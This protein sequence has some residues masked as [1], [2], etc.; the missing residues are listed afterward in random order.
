[1]PQRE[2]PT[3]PLVGVGAIIV[4]EQARVLLIQ[5]GAEPMK[6][7]WSLPGGLL[8]LGETLVEGVIREVNEETGLTVK[9][10]AIVDVVDRIYTFSDDEKSQV[11]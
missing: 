8:E 1:M 5:R 10:E 4:D 3:A 9:P 6:G 7:H 2:F 11:R